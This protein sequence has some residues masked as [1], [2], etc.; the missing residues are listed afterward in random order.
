[1]PFNQAI[2]LNS[3]VNYDQAEKRYLLSV[4]AKDKQN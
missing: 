3:N 4:V 2:Q 1:M